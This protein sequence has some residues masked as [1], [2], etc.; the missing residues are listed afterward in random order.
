MSDVYDRT[1]VTC[2]HKIDDHDAGE[3][4]NHEAPDDP[5]EAW[6]S[7]LEEV[8]GQ[9]WWQQLTPDNLRSPA[10]TPLTT[11]QGALDE[12]NPATAGKGAG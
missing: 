4:W 7:A 12:K 6:L 5:R 11:F 9:G 8:K 3:C 2:G 1:C 10:Y